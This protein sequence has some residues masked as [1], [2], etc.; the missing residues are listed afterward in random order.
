MNLRFSWSTWSTF[1]IAAGLSTLLSTLVSCGAER[2]QM[3]PQV[4]SQSPQSIDVTQSSP[5][6]SRSI[7]GNTLQVQSAQAQTAQAQTGLQAPETPLPPETQA[8][9]SQLGDRPLFDPPR[10]DVRLVVISDLN[11]A[12][13]STDYDPEVDKG[14]ALVPFW[15]P[16]LVICG[17]D[18]VAGQQ[19]SLTAA[20]IGPCGQPLTI[21][22]LGCCGAIRFPLASRSAIMM[23]PQSKPVREILPSPKSEI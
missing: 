14:L 5:S 3:P 9:L 20:E 23:R 1:T 2:S 13:G 7:P 16:D 18:M 21:G 6:L 15:Q 8:I 10:G 11:S 22:C 17:G 12:Y 4:L 19:A